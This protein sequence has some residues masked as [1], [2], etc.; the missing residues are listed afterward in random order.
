MNKVRRETLAQILSD[1]DE[2]IITSVAETEPVALSFI[3]RVSEICDQEDEAYAN[4]P[5]NFMYSERAETMAENIDSFQTALDIL[6]EATGAESIDDFLENIQE[7][8]SALEEIA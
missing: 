4:I 7:A 3:S 5:E 2:V 1:M 6:E 8:K